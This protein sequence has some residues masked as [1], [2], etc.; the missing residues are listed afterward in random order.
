LRTPFGRAKAKTATSRPE[1]P[2]T[3]SVPP[4]TSRDL[5]T[6]TSSPLPPYSWSRPAPPKIMSSP[7]PHMT[8]S[9][10]ASARTS[11]GAAVQFSRLPFAVP[12][13]VT[14]STANPIV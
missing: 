10:P 2:L 14:P 13:S 9:L 4:P 6:N 11:V 12:R 1:P 5:R 3:C 8:R 7:A